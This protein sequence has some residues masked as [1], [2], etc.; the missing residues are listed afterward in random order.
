MNRCVQVMRK[1]AVPK[2]VVLFPF[3][4]GSGYSY[5]E[6]IKTI[7]AD[8]EMIVVNPPGRL[9]DGAKPLESIEA[10]VVLYAKELRALL[11][12]NLLFFG[13][14]IGGIVAYETCKALQKEFKIKKMIISNISPPHRAREN[15]DLHSG[16][17]KET[18]IQKS[19]ALGGMPQLFK[20]EAEL[21]ETF[22]SGL[23]ADLKALES[24]NPEPPANVKKI[25]I[26]TSVLYSTGD[27]IVDT[28]SLGD[29]KHYLE[30][31]EFVEFTG[32]HFYLFE[33]SNRKKVAGIIAKH[34]NRLGTAL[35][36]FQ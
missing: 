22:I 34:I 29:W 9:L 15:V 16:M 24:Y 32:D 36:S 23:R 18:L 26:D 3:G 14:S 19:T 6:L 35:P 25:N 2:Q 17:D 7:D 11:K 31:S 27:Y 30:C 5:M 21:L 4:G 1:A 13:H 8:A 20:N 10:M 12:E 33:E 28:S